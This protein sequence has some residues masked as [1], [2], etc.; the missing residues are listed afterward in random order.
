LQETVELV[1]A[2]VDTVPEGAVPKHQ[3]MG[4]DPD[5]PTVQEAPGKAAAA[6]YYDRYL[7]LVNQWVTTSSP[8]STGG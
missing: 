6:V 4:D 7:A 8:L 1:R 5:V 2:Y 3:L